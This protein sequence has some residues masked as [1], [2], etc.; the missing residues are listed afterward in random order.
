MTDKIKTLLDMIA[1]TFPAI[2]VA[3][4]T[5]EEGNKID[6][7]KGALEDF[8]MHCKN[9]S[10]ATLDS[11]YLEKFYCGVSY[12]D[13]QSWLAYLPALLTYA[14]T[15]VN[16]GTGLPTDALLSS[17]RPGSCHFEYFRTCSENIRKVTFAVLEFLATESNS[18]F[19]EDA[20]QVIQEYDDYAKNQSGG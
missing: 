16:S 13:A 12:L 3:T 15:H 6:E 19:E 5:L 9:I 11:I 1:D 20:L 7:Y 2:A 14:V 4:V 10:W 17:L 8:S 18:Q